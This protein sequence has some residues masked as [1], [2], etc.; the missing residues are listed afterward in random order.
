MTNDPT[1]KQDMVDATNEDGQPIG[2]VLASNYCLFMF[3][4]NT[5]QWTSMGQ[6]RHHAMFGGGARLDGS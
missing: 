3:C 2:K 6:T 4:L 5:V 1:T